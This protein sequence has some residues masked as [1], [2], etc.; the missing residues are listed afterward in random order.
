VTRPPA[1]RP[2]GPLAD[3]LLRVVLHVGQ[4]ALPRYGMRERAGA[5]RR[6]DVVLRAALFCDLA[7]A[8]LLS[9]T[10]GPVAES[11]PR[12]GT[13]AGAAGSGTASGGGATSGGA[14]GREALGGGAAGGEAP[15]GGAPG[16]GA[17]GGGGAPRG[18]APGGSSDA[19]SNGV[20]QDQILSAVLAAV[21]QRPGVAWPRW[22]RHVRDDRS[23]LVARLVGSG[24]WVALGGH[25]FRDVDPLAAER[26][27]ARTFTVSEL[28][29]APVD[30]RETVL[31]YL[32]ALTG[33]AMTPEHVLG[34]EVRL[35]RLDLAPGG[36]SVRAVLAAARAV[37]RRGRFSRR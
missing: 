16:V 34:W 8:G 13:A 23:A 21:A 31:G 37:N 7:R 11:G 14:P 26:L 17:E 18:A 15:G 35:A 3:D 5:A 9:G 28:V 30:E 33:P 12:R 29:E 27:Q 10:R 22:F 19:V 25:R 4:G 36:A 6:L 1:S 20:A 32:Y 2:P 24:R